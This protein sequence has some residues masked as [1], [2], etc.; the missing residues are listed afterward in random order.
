[1]HDQ[2]TNALLAVLLGT[3]LAIVLLLPVT[4][5]LYRREGRLGIRS[6]MVLLAAAIYGV[7]LWTY[8]LLP[9]PSRSDVRC[10]GSQ[11]APFA[12]LDDILD[13]GA[14]SA[15]ELLANPAFLQVA[16][17]V[18]LFVPFGFF[19]RRIL[20]RGVVVAGLLGLAVSLLIETT[21]RTG[22]WGFYHCAYRVFDV[23]DLITNTTGAI[24]GSLLSALVVPRHTRRRPLPTQVSLG[25][26]WMGMVC[27]GLA[28]SAL[29]FA[30]DVSWRAFH[31]YG[32]GDTR[33][34]DGAL[35]R[36]L[37]WGSAGAVQLV[38]V[39]MAGRTI[40]E[41]AIAVETTASRPGLALPGRLV[42][43]VCG[44]GAFA[45][46]SAWEGPGWIL[47]V[48]LAVTVLA[49]WPGADHPGLATRLGGLKLG[50]AQTEERATVT[51]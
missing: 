43:W 13:R 30:V 31:L 18:A 15:G 19:V 47:N 41:W 22:V 28:T 24:L 26:R 23:D 39:L 35:E 34:L 25:R 9:A 46:L 16:L 37:A 50:V 14:G 40:G 8:T 45:A 51:P 4:A 7:A 20:R 33:Y 5:V 32:G 29:A 2:A 12:S 6:L 27:D 10:V 1:M 44:I 49:A 17:N 48:F 21:Q 36:W 11:T 3:G 42:K 38:V